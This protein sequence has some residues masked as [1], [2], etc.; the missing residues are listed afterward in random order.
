MK[1]DFP[2][3]PPASAATEFSL[4]IISALEKTKSVGSVICFIL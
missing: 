1:K 3:L 4:D 2:T